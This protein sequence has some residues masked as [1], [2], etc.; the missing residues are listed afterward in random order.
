M[1]TITAK[2]LRDNLEEV[3]KRVRSGEHINVTHRSKPAF[4]II[5]SI[6]TTKVRPRHSGLD[7]LLA[8]PNRGVLDT[9]SKSYKELYDDH[10]NEKYSA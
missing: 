10:V 9:P 8:I 2:E 1:N 6:D 5:P 3:T 7:A 4:T